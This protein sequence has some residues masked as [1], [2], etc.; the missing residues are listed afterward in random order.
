MT[1]FKMDL[2]LFKSALTILMYTQSTVVQT[3]LVVAN[4]L[5]VNW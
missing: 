3:L 4:L 5:F 2:R 1:A